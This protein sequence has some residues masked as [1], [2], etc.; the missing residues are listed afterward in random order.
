[1]ANRK[2]PAVIHVP[3][4]FVALCLICCAI[5]LLLFID[6]T[7]VHSPTREKHGHRDARGNMNRD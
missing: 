1:L 4:G 2:A 7:T 3:I 5:A 6:V